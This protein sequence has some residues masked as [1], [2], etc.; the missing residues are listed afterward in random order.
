MTLDKKDIIFSIVSIVLVCFMT[1]PIPA[2]IIHICLGINNIALPILVLGFSKKINLILLLEILILMSLSRF[3]LMIASTRCI[4]LEKSADIIKLFEFNNFNNK[5]G[6]DYI[7]E[8]T[9]YVFIFIFVLFLLFIPLF[10]N[11]LKVNILKKDVLSKEI[12]NLKEKIQGSN[13]EEEVSYMLT[14][15]FKFIKAE[16]TIVI[17]LLF[18]DIIFCIFGIHYMNFDINTAIKNYILLG[19]DRSLIYQMSIITALVILLFRFPKRFK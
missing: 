15:F 10:V 1:I 12:N 7:L 5:F 9:L 6:N 3:A 2:N 11:Y 18:V 19:F 8:I 13:V 17:C 4:L 14:R 16:Y